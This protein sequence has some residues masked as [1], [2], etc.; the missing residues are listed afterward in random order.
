MSH[1][2]QRRWNIE[3]DMYIKT[4]VN[5]HGSRW[6]EILKGLP[7]DRTVSSVRN[8]WQRMEKHKQTMLCCNR[9]RI[10]KQL[11]RGHSCTGFKRDDADGADGADGVDGADDA[12]G[13]DGGGAD[14]GDCADGANYAD[15]T[16]GTDGANYVDGADYVDGVKIYNEI[17]CMINDLPE[18]FDD[19]YRD[20]VDEHMKTD[21]MVTMMKVAS[22]VYDAIKC[23]K[24]VYTADRWQEDGHIALYQISESLM[25]FNIWQSTVYI[26][27]THQQVITNLMK[28]ITISL[29]LLMLDV[30]SSR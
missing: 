13:A 9:C 10:C 21:V 24:C 4:M 2:H 22:G 6:N 17:E 18:L 20:I 30:E 12:D 14:G 19:I 8:R 23:A 29:Q 28:S 11:Q 5:E 25:S 1:V 15:G 16:D 27:D 3:E 26:D 7:E